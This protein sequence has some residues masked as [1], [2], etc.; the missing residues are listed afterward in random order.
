MSVSRDNEL[1][2]K[3]DMPWREADNLG[4]DDNDDDGGRPRRLADAD[5]SREE[6]RGGQ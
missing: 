5:E 1:E 6:G 2:G 3:E 4:I